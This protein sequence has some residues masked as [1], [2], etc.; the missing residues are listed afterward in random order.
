M[1]QE[2]DM[3]PREGVLCFQYMSDFTPNDTQV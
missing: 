1:N 3:C 2:S